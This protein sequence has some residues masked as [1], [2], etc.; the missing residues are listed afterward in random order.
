MNNAQINALPVVMHR[1][2][3]HRA[4][5]PRIF[6]RSAAILLMLCMT[7][8]GIL[9]KK[10][11][12]QV[13]APHVK[14]APDAS[15]PGVSWQLAVA[16]PTTSKLLD[17]SHIVVS[18]TPETL[19][20]YHAASWTDSVP[21]LLQSIVAE[22]FEDSG[23]ITAVARQ[24]T[25]VRADFLLLL[26]IRHFEAVYAN[27][28]LNSRAGQSPPNTLI[29]VSAKLVDSNGH[30]IAART[31]S[32]TTAASGIA[33]PAV[34]EAFNIGLSGLTRELVGWTLNAGQQAQAATKTPK[35]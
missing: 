17:S 8:C 33:V 9:P 21:E 18:P 28:A 13:I 16:R 31:F 7:G 11:N 20:V 2:S 35:K 15:W 29:E 27:P 5:A 3:T 25:A 4:F 34:T 22:A 12:I 26:D 23:K 1:S 32:Q 19:Q 24:A 30:V 10:E 6:A 14:V